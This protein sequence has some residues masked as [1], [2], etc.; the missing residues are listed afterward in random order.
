MTIK[1]EKTGRFVASYD[2]YVK[3][4][5][6]KQAQLQRMGYKM[7]DE[8]YTEKQWKAAYHLGKK[9]AR[10]RGEK[11]SNRALVDEQAY[12][13]SKAQVQAY[14]NATEG[15][16]KYV[17]GKAF[18]KLRLGADDQVAGLLEDTSEEYWKLKEE[19]PNLSPADLSRML[20]TMFWGS[21]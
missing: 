14:I 15:P 9:E 3:E 5:N 12:R 11:F 4:Y 20:A 17:S 21:K 18:N 2:T 7:D 1:D 6:K 13:F 16:F 8:M 10:G 19:Y